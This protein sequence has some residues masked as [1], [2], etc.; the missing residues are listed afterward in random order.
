MRLKTLFSRSWLKTTILV[1]AAVLV[2]VRLG[3]WQ[4]DRL[5]QRRSFNERVTAQLAAE[6]LELSPQNLDLDLYNMEYREAEV[7][8]KFDHQHQVVLR[9]QDWQGNL[10]VHILTPLMIEGEQKAI[11]VDRG[12][13]PYEDFVAGNL[14]Q[15]DDPGS[16]Q[17]MGTIRRSQSKPLIGGRADILPSPGEPALSAW[18]W[19]N[20]SNI[21]RQI[22]YD[23]LPV[24]LVR[25]P[26]STE[27]QLPYRTQQELELTEGSHLGYAFQWFTFA[28]IL[29]IGYPIFVRKEE[30]RRSNTSRNQTPFIHTKNSKKQDPDQNAKDG[31]E[32]A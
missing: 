11:L 23:L 4:L 24:Y 6:L 27:N 31:Y 21:S 32:Q 15:Y 17:I 1:I 14:A 8:G 26:D 2:M 20:I 7:S 22:P 13:V 19:I 30:Q 12:W 16:L 5:T 29:A 10:G 18:N 9:N 3:F 25:M 28:A